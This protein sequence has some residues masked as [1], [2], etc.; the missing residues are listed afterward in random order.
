MPITNPWL[1]G[2]TP[3]GVLARAEL[4]ERI[5][6]LLSINN[7]VVIAT[8]TDDGSPAATPVRYFS[9]GFEN[10]YTS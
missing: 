4:E 9:L 6:N 10:F 1:A 2:P 3:D 7:T 8:V 5:L